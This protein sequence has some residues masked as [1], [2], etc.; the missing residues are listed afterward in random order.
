[1]PKWPA[2]WAANF[3]L[4]YA[5]P[6]S[7]AAS[8]YHQ[9]RQEPAADLASNHGTAVASRKPAPPERNG[10]A[11]NRPDSTEHR[12]PSAEELVCWTGRERFRFLWYR[13]RLTISEINYAQRRLFELQ[14][15]L[16]TEWPA[17]P[18]SASKKG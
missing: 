18:P 5:S 9:W 3:L 1:M 7:Q 14:T 13:L 2:R 11:M 10:P 6:L 17:P 8:R 15:R 4:G 16:P 12:M